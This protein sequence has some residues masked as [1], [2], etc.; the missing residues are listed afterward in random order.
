MSRIGNR[1]LTL[2]DGVTATVEGNKITVKGSKG[3]LSYNFS[4]LIEVKVEDG[5][6]T[7]T[8]KKESKEAAGSKSGICYLSYELFDDGRK[9]YLE[10][11]R[12][13][14]LTMLHVSVTYKLKDYLE[15]T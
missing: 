1:K 10:Y 13:R 11:K 4:N 12:G 3:E 7:T 14:K 5:A 6:V 2:A 15:M 9:E 8:Q